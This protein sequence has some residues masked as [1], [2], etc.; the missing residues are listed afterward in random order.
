MIV[1]R[2]VAVEKGMNKETKVAAAAGAVGAVGGGVV[3]GGVV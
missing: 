3:G 1:R 2:L